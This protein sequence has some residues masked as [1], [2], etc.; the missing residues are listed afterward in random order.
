MNYNSAYIIFLLDPDKTIRENETSTI[1]CEI[2]YVIS[3]TSATY[4]R[5]DE[6]TRKSQMNYKC[7]SINVQRAVHAKCDG[8]QVCRL[9][10]SNQEFGNPCSEVAK[11]LKLNFQCIA[12][13]IAGIFL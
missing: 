4:G 10:A 9:T 1:E 3:V 8:K 7:T 6:T 12:S 5:S 11:C 2:G 13:K